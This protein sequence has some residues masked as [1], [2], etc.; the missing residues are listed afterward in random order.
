MF[1]FKS[2][3]PIKW[4]KFNKNFV[5][6]LSIAAIIALLDLLSKRVIFNYLD[7]HGDINQ[8]GSFL[9]ITGFFNLVKVENNGVS[10]GLFSN[11]QYSYITFSILQSVIG[12]A[13]IIWSL[14]NQKLIISFSL[15]LIAGGAFGNAIDRIIT[16]KVAD[17]L[18]FYWQNYHW[19]AFNLADSAVFIGVCIF[20][21]HDFFGKNKQNIG[22]NNNDNQ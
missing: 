8:F 20:I 13:I 6:S 17:F 22:Q 21:W 19:P 12:L 7:S 11:W 5:I 2:C 10:F 3:S 15:G 14:Y 4:Q 1:F 16:G 18:D 9:N